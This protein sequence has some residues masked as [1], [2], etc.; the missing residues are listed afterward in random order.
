MCRYSIRIFL[1]ESRFIDSVIQADT[2]FNAQLLGQGQSP[3]GKAI[4]LGEA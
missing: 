3:V 4:F 2:W 1:S